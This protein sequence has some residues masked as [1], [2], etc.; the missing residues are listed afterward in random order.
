MSKL[1]G[2]LTKQ[3]TLIK[4]LFVTV[5]ALGALDY[6]TFTYWEKERKRLTRMTDS[7]QTKYGVNA[8]SEFLKS[9]CAL[10]ITP[11]LNNI[12]AFDQFKNMDDDY[13]TELN[14]KNLLD[15]NVDWD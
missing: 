6:V 10:L 12:H 2:V 7:F 11:S 9:N 8:Q 15:N 3:S 4:G 5:G 14:V 13:I 1:W